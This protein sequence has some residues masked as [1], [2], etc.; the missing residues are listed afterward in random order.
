MERNLGAIGLDVE[1]KRFPPPVLFAKLAT[2]GEPFDIGWIGWTVIDG[3]ALAD[4]FDGRRLGEPTIFNYSYFNSP[5]YNRLIDAA[6][7]LPLGPARD[8]AWGELDVSL[9]RE[10][11]PGIP[12][13][14]TNAFTFVSARTGCVVRNPYLDLTAVCLK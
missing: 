11:A 10:A 7:R 2:R 9:S 5:K 1:I 4:F 3:S 8:R 13:A 6:S 14:V 12:Y